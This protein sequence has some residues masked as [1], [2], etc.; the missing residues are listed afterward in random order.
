MTRIEELKCI[1]RDLDRQMSEAVENCDLA[2][3]D[4]IYAIKEP[5][6]DELIALL[7]K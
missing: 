2:K 3:R 4:A 7:D 6:Y 1:C 5:Y